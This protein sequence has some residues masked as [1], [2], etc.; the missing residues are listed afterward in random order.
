MLA[1]VLAGV[2]ACAGYAN[3]P[4]QTLEGCWR[5]CWGSCKL[6]MCARC[7]S[8]ATAHVRVCACPDAVGG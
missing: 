8:W 6:A 2:G 4:G 5:R 3:T 7:A 1:G